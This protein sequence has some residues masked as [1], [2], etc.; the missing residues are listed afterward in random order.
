MYRVSQKMPFKDLGKTGQYFPKLFLNFKV[1][2]KKVRPL[3]FLQ[4]SFSKKASCSKKFLGFLRK[5]GQYFPKLFL[6]F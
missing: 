4:N 5:T 3:I 1:S 6:N 2:W